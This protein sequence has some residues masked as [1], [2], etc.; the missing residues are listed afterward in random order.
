MFIDFHYSFPSSHW[1]IQNQYFLKHWYFSILNTMINHSMEFSSHKALFSS[2]IT[3]FNNVSFIDSTYWFASSL[4]NENCPFQSFYGL[5]FWLTKIVRFNHSMDFSSHKA[6]FSSSITTFYNVSF[7]DSTLRF[8]SSLIN[9]NWSFQSFFGVQFSQSPFFLINNSIPLC[10]FHWFYILICIINENCPF[11]SFC[12][13]QIS[14]RSF[15]L[16]NNYIL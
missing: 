9:E 6:L 14:Q 7:I 15:S 10:E 5:Q 11:Q 2:S 8:A 4:I 12:G 1:S 16:I 13:V 3:R